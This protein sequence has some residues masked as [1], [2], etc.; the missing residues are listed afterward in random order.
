VSLNPK[1]VDPYY[2]MFEYLNSR[3]NFKQMA[4]VM[5]LGV[6]NLPNNTD[7]HEYLILAY[8]KMGNEDLALQEMNEVLKLKPKDVSLLLDVAKLSEK[9]GKDKEA[10]AAYKRI[11]EV[12]PGNEEAG[13]AYLRLRLEQLPQEEKGANE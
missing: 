2:F 3:G 6:S 9:L 10:L 7:L 12:S 8:L 13:A 4:D 5:K 11:L 1:E